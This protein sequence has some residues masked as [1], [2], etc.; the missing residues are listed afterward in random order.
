MGENDK[1]KICYRILTYFGILIGIDATI[2]TNDD[3]IVMVEKLE[4]LSYDK[5]LVIEEHLYT[6]YYE[7]SHKEEE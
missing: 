3:I 6:I 7:Q 1:R 2:I 5:L 4:K